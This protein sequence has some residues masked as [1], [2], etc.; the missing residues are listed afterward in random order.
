SDFQSVR[1]LAIYSKKQGISL[2]ELASC[3]RLN[4]YIKNIG[5]NFDLIEPF[6]ANLAKSSEP[7]ELINVANEIAQLSTSESIPLNALTDHIKQ[8]QQENQILE[9]EIKQADAILE[10]KNADIQ[11][12]SEYTQ[13]KEEL[14]KH[15]VSI[16]D[17]NRLLAILKSIRSMKYDPKKIVAE[18]SHLKS[19]RRQERILKNSCQI[20][21][22]RITEYRLVVPLLQQIRS[23]GIGIDK[24]LPFSFAVTEKAQT[25]NLSISA[26][27]YHVIEDI[28]NYNKIG[29]LKKEISRLAAQIYAMNE[30][31]A[32]RNKTITALLKLQAF[33]ITDGEILN[34]YEY[35]KRAR[36]ENAAKIQR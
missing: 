15:G 29:G 28:Q 30:M 34:V 16:E 31:S 4:N 10:N 17:C 12:I 36:L 9:K 24:L 26:A 22:S 20:L 14:S 21:E 23:M 3:I 1:E 35:L 32:A 25:S 13:L 8:Q 11:T 27:A 2:N 7:Q 5:T 6:I 19:R 18:F 33:G